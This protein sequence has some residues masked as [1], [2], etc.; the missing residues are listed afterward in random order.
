MMSVEVDYIKDKL[1][2]LNHKHAIWGGCFLLVVLVG[3][4]YFWISRPIIVMDAGQAGIQVKNNGGMD[5]L[6]HKINGFWYWAGR[7]AL[8]TNMPDI[9]QRVEPGTAPVRLQIPDMP[10]P[11]KQATETT[12]CFMKLEVH[13]RI[14]GMPIFRYTTPLYFEYDAESK[15]WAATETIPVKHRSLGKLTVGNI[16]KVK[17]NFH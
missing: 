8:L 12:A 10:I 13:Y 14:P 6:I 5:A 16:G 3:L 9:R 15:I 7:V 2:N 17:L 4:G 1:K 11:G